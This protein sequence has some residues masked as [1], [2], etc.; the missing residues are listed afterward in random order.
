MKLNK[1]FQEILLGF[2]RAVDLM[3]KPEKI[4][5]LFASGLMLLTGIL[6]NFP[7]II[8]GKLVDKLVGSN[9]FQYPSKTRIF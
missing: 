9:G 1:E 7:A 5:L 4:S 8:L 6:T 3:E 2:K